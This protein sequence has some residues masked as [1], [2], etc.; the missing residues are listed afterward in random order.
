[1][2]CSIG[3]TDEQAR[4]KIPQDILERFESGNRLY[5]LIGSPDTIRARLADLEA[6]GVQELIVSFP[7]VLHLDSLRFFA[8]EFIEPEQTLAQAG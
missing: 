6:A 2:I 5:T 4:A 1:G 3:A 8:H 7:D